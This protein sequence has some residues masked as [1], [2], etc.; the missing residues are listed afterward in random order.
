[1]LKLPKIESKEYSD[2]IENLIGKLGSFSDEYTGESDIG[3]MLLELFAY[4]KLQQRSNMNKITENG[5]KALG[6]LIGEKPFELTPSEMIISGGEN[7]YIPECQ[8]LRF[9]DVVF[10]PSEEYFRPE[11]DISA[12][13]CFNNTTFIKQNLITEIQLF[14]KYDNFVIGLEKSTE[15]IDIFFS[16]KNIGRNKITNKKEFVLPD[17]LEWQYYGT[18]DGKTEWHTAEVV[19]DETISFLESGKVSLKI[20]GKH[21]PLDGIFPIKCVLKENCYDILPAITDIRIDFLKAIQK[22]T[23]CACIEFSYDDFARNEMYF[24]NCLAESDRYITFINIGTGYVRSSDIRINTQILKEE[25][26]FRLATSS[27]SELSELFSSKE[28]TGE[29]TAIK[30]VLYEQAYIYDFTVFSS[31]ETSNQSLDLNFL[32]TIPSS[33]RIMTAY[34]YDGLLCFDEW[35]KVDDI[36][37]CS[38]DDK[39]FELSENKIIFGDGINGTIPKKTGGEYDI[40]VTSLSLSIGERGNTSAQ[41]IKDLSVVSRLTA[42]TGGKNFEQPDEFYCRILKR[43]ADHALL[44]VDDFEYYTKNTQGILAEN[45][46]VLKGKE[47]NSVDI[48]VEPRY[49]IEKANIDWY[50]E[51]ISANIEKFRLLATKVNVKFPKNIPIEISVFI[52][53]SNIFENIDEIIENEIKKYL[54]EW[55]AKKHTELRFIEFQ[56]KLNLLDCVAEAKRISIT[57]RSSDTVTERNILKL[58]IGCK[59]HLSKLKIDYIRG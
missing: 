49:T 46:T 20:K 53:K 47:E 16:I 13:G 33:L 45:I 3:V 14:E 25:N 39:A 36:K 43:K 52:K 34:E 5:I 56:S 22:D 31:D 54:S 18:L 28:I 17:F 10:E 2:E 27:R 50:I 26:R 51:N 8:K 37:K 32:G 7:K 24:S 29:K 21:E 9:D 23:K 40:I 15:S 55:N 48:I 35:K 6:K 4:I 1:M 58:P 42:S 11:N 30:L 38:P 57:S 19:S 59:L 44:S 12:I 41:A